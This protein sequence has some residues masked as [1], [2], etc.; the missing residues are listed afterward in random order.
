VRLE[1]WGERW[2]FLGKPKAGKSTMAATYPDYLALNLDGAMNKYVYPKDKRIDCYN[3]DDI[4]T[5]FGEARKRSDWSS[6]ILDPIDKV[7][8][9]I[10][11]D[12]CDKA[13]K[14][15]IADVGHGGGY[16]RQVAQFV[17]VLDTFWNI[18]ESRP[19]LCASIICAHSKSG[20]D[21]QSLVIRKA[22]HTY[23]QGSVNNIIYIS[24][25]KTSEGLNFRADLSG[26]D[27][28]E[29]GCRNP[30]L[31]TA[32]IIP[33]SFTSIIEQFNPSRAAMDKAYSWLE[34]KGGVDRQAFITKARS[35]GLMTDLEL[36]EKIRE[37]R[38]KPAVLDLIKRS[39]A[40]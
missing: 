22:L 20:D 21:G 36:Y 28:I 5:A 14:A 39:L 13:H 2:L 16:S 25:T 11:A 4:K 26:S 34:S 40:Q 32:G 7:V 35:M 15:S 38:E 19:N 10:N 18:A 6:L 3:L 29:A 1:I 9:W 37:C 31:M 23:L 33:A 24:K 12:I 27:K 30:T 17:Q 8:T